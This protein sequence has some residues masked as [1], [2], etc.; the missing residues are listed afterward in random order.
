MAPSQ[1]TSTG[2]ISDPATMPAIDAGS[3]SPYA[4]PNT[5]SGSVRCSAVSVMISTP[6]APVPVRPAS[7]IA[8][9]P[10]CAAGSASVGSPTRASAATSAVRC[11]S[12]AARP[13]SA[14]PSTPPAP[15]PANRYP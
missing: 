5:S 1:L 6:I 9:G 4:R 11:G 12:R 7:R 8:A 15:M 10:Q 2:A 14:V 13:A 3:A